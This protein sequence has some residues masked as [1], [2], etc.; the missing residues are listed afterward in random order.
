M[1]NWRTLG[2]A[3][4][5]LALAFSVG[6]CKGRR[7]TTTGISGANVIGDLPPLEGDLVPM[8]GEKIEGETVDVKFE[9]VYFDYDSSQ[10]KPAE[11]A[12]IEAA[13]DYLK[14]NPALKVIVE[15]HCDERGSAEYH[16]ALGE[17]RAQSVRSYL[18]G[19]GIAAERVQTAS[20]GEERPAVPGAG[21]AAWSK[22]RRAEFVVIR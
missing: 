20:F 11:R 4:F 18:I 7:P 2:L 8:E 21:E 9:P 19:L 14:K 22:N 5:S 6:G 17:R 15:G 3:A 16:L 1:S 13:A 10:V 12:K